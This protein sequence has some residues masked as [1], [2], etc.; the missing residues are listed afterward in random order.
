MAVLDWLPRLMYRYNHLDLLL[1]AG[2]AHCLVRSC[3]SRLVDLHLQQECRRSRSE[4]PGA[5]DMHCWFDANRSDTAE[6]MYK[7]LTEQL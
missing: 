7:H 1:A 4:E 6:G 3:F 5:E 2:Y